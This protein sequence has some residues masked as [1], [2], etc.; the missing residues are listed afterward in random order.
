[1][2]CVGLWEALGGHQRWLRQ[3]QYTILRRDTILCLV[4]MRKSTT[5][6][7]N[8]HFHFNSKS[9][10]ARQ[11]QCRVF[12]LW[13]RVRVNYKWATRAIPRIFAMQSGHIM[14]YERLKE[15]F[16]SRVRK[17]NGIKHVWI[18]NIISCFIRRLS[19][20]THSLNARSAHLSLGMS[21]QHS[22]KKMIKK[23][24]RRWRR[25]ARQR[26]RRNK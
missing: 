5:R 25:P 7:H 19:A 8:F 9:C 23:I 17:T 6:T 20:Q 24:W 15:E 12:R 16:V 18:Y 3:V 21:S 26:H 11:W 4:C 13:A 22:D 1:M 2:N 14:R 10:T